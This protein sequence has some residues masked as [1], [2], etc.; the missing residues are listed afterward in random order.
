MKQEMRMIGRL[1]Q[2]LAEFLI[3]IEAIKFGAFRL[4]LHEKNPEAPLSPIYVDLRLLRSYPDAMDVAVDTY[5][6][7]TK[8]LKMDLYADIPT[9]ATPMVALLSHRTRIPMISPRKGE[10]EHGRLVSIDGAFRAGQ[11]VVVIDDLITRADSK[12]EAIRVL[13]EKGLTVKDVV[14]LIDREQG[15]AQELA[16]KGYT[17]HA[18]LSLR[19][20][21]LFYRDSNSITEE[22]FEK[23]MTYIAGTSV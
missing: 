16:A 17:C 20:L 14:V 23:T 22:E 1:E 9:A 12:F 15:G 8:G 11:V 6:E 21:L 18:A 10:K 13:E 4:K 7:L 19:E 3:R 2:R 5:I